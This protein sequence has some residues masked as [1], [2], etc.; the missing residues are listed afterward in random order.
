MGIFG[1]IKSR[2]SHRDEDLG[3]L[4]SHVLGENPYG[5]PESFAPRPEPMEQE[6]A[7]DFRRPEP[8]PPPGREPLTLE[9]AAYEEP[10]P[11]RENISFEPTRTESDSYEIL[12]RL[13]FIESQLAAIRSQTELINER[14]KNLEVRL[15]RRY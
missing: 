12:D 13:K 15:G 9:P 11:T 7:R 2:I 4:R 6:F 3:D 14:L 10:F 8:L 5:P 1:R